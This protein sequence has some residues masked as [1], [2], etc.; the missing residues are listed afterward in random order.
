MALRVM[1]FVALLGTAAAAQVSVGGEAGVGLPLSE[2]Q[3]TY[4]S[5][6]GVGAI[7][8]HLPV[9]SALDLGA[10]LGYLV[11]PSTAA[12][13]YAGPGSLLGLG[14]SARLHRPYG[15]DVEVVPFVDFGG[16]FAFDGRFSALGLEGAVGL[17]F[18]LLERRLLL[19]PVLRLTG[20]PV[21]G[22][23]EG[24][25]GHS[26]MVLSAGLSVEWLSA[27]PGPLDT[28]SDGVPDEKD[29]CP[30]VRGSA[31]A[32]GCPDADGDGVADS[33][34]KCPALAGTAAA[35]G[36]PDSDGDGVIDAEDRC[37]KEAGTVA[38]HGCPAPKVNPDEDGDGLLN[39]VDECPTVQGP[40]ALSG[41]PD[42][43]NDGV[44]DKNDACPD[45]A[46]PKDNLG[47]PRYQNVTVTGSR[48]EIGQK[49]FFAFGL[50]KILPKSN[51]LLS[52]VVQALAD[53]ASLCVRIEGH[54]DNVGDAEKN[55]SLSDG[56]AKAIAEYLAEH[57]VSAA[58]LQAKGFGAT[59]PIDNNA[60]PEGRDRNRRVEFTIIPC[61]EGT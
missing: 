42:R 41:C 23:D 39:E 53:H 31:A 32:G 52:E 45:V 13:P 51:G 5:P 29:A 60:T 10:R 22:V 33:D 36:C 12:S 1:S 18:A 4:F 55:L 26:A 59:L 47:C 19:G 61:G 25:Q 54:T 15:P 21:L 38:T 30:T 16:A 50:T 2:P 48:I 7:G 9:L 20:V 46:G 3:R 6:G 57:G 28:D 27:S 11:L 43:D 56:R 37:P 35:G 58:R 8:A 44:A 17:H 49:I 40:K 24:W 14:F 34:D